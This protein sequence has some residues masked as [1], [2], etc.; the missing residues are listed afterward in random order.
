MKIFDGYRHT[1]GLK[2]DEKITEHIGSAIA[3]IWKYL[4][5]YR[6]G[7]IICFVLS[8]TM[9]LISLATSVLSKHVIDAVIGKNTKVFFIAAVLAVILYI[10]ST[11]VG[12]IVNRKMFDINTSA[13][14]DIRKDVFRKI[15]DVSWENLL[16]FRPG[17]LINRAKGETGILAEGFVGNVFGFIR[18]AV[19]LIGS[20]IIIIQYD[21][22]FAV[23]AIVGAPV[24]ALT[25]RSLTKKM[26]ELSKETKI[27]ESEVMAFSSE[28]MYNLQ[29]VKSFSIAG[30]KIV[31]LVAVLNRNKNVKTKQ[32][33]YSIFVN[34]F[35]GFLGILA[36]YS[37]LAWAIYRLWRGEISYGTMTMFIQL[38][39]YAMTSMKGLI[40]FFPSL[41]NTATSVMRIREV[42][43]LEPEDPDAEE[44][45]K[46]LAQRVKSKICGIRIGGADISYKT[47]KNVL[48]DINL[49]INSDSGTAAIIGPSGGG[50]TTIFRVMLGLI[51]P[52]KGK[53]K[54][55]TTDGEEIE[56]SPCTR[57]LFA[58]VP[59]GNTTFSGSIADNI[60][61]VNTEMSDDDIENVL[62]LACA[63]DFV[64]QLPD[65]I[66]TVIGE[67]GHGLSEGQAQRIA[68]ARAIACDAPIILFDEAT[69]ALDMRTERT[70]LK[71]ISEAENSR[72][73]IFSTHRFSVLDIC[74]TIFKVENRRLEKITYDE[75]KDYCLNI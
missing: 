5:R 31:Q 66:N 2:K 70:V 51:N 26:K 13:T 50:K 58:Y 1:L 12:I 47:K 42:T 54:I 75:A 71:N 11:F 8:I 68:I 63:Y 21:W 18:N 7:L 40:S 45:A 55:I 62:R 28:T 19:I 39:S 69:S 49:D 22:V 20:L 14:N 27:S 24:L 52:E 4:S 34:T 72:I 36:S 73:C 67:K 10:V 9:T 15:F 46:Q 6:T 16:S 57:K 30:L 32:N 23:I 65:G 64:S 35:I 41:I 61:V 74:D 59:Q 43:E 38:A 17:D 56:I 33:D 37:C 3:W 25:Y 53:A 48:T 29:T 60:R 44:K